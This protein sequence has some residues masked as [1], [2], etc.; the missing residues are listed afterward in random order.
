MKILLNGNQIGV[1]RELPTLR[2]YY[3]H[4]FN[5]SGRVVKD[6]EECKKLA[7]KALSKKITFQ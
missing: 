6:L 7:M 1:I 4:A 2:G 3:W 5:R